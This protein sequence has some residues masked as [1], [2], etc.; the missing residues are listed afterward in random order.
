MGE[1]SHIITVKE[2]AEFYNL[3]I[4]QIQ[5]KA[6]REGL[7]KSGTS[8]LIEHKDLHLFEPIYNNPNSPGRN[9]V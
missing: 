8:Y 7:K 4:R 5:R 6:K 2:I 3:S 1:T 9:K